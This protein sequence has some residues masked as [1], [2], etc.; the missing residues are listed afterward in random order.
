M[1]LNKIQMKVG[2]RT[3]MTD[4]GDNIGH[5]FND[6]YGAELV[7]RFNDHARLE[8]A[9]Q[10]AQSETDD[11]EDEISELE[12]TVRELKAE[13]REHRD[14]LAI[15]DKTIHDLQEKLAQYAD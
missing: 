4:K 1:K 3:M 15:Y 9:L 13:I 5:V 7:R 11:L 10:E 6:L 12:E 2:T 8:E 14:E